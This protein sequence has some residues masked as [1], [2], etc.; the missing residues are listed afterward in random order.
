MGETGETCE[1]G[2]DF[3]LFRRGIPAFNGAELKF[4]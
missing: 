1:T 2:E 4:S 3:D